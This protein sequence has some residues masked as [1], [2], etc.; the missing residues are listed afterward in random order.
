MVRSSFKIGEFFRLV[1]PAESKTCKNAGA[2]SMSPS[3]V[4]WSCQVLLILPST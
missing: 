2:P 1:L 4:V 3:M